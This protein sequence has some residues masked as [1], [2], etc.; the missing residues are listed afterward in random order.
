[1]RA[2][3]LVCALVAVASCKPADDVWE[4]W[5]SKYGKVYESRV[6]ESVRRANW[7][8]RAAE[9]SLHNLE[10]SLG[11]HSWTEEMNF[12][13]DL[14]HDEYLAMLTPMKLSAHQIDAEHMHEESASTPATQD[15]TT[16]GR[17]TG[18]KDQGQCGSCWS[19]SATGGL[20]GAWSASNSLVSLSEQQLV[21]CDTNDF[22]C[23]G[24]WY[25]SAWEYLISYGGS[26]SEASYGYVSGNGGVPACQESSYPIVA[27]LS[28][29][30]CTAKGS[31][32]ALQDAVGNI[33]PVSIAID[34]AM[35]SFS[36]YKSGVYAPTSCPVNYLDH[37]V[38]AVGYNS[39]N[40]QDYWIVKNSWGTS[41]GQQGYIWMARNDNNLCG[42]ANGP[43]CYPT[44]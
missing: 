21:S 24:G 16:Q 22:G 2:V 23:N 31:E 18:V 7:E 20:E 19:F 11:M 8:K 39:L 34:A 43:P 25:Y 10:E 17:V 1:M 41:W 37:A 35:P 3:I 13:Q 30:K 36:S 32:S 5:K 15:W 28:S 44:L 42:I 38:L 29:Y 26:V 12:L 9:V 40:G 33:G 4:A 6:E 14:S 27:K